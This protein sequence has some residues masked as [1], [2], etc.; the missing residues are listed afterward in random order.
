MREDSRNYGAPGGNDLHWHDGS[1]CHGA[2]TLEAC[3][4]HAISS[5][6]A[7][8][9]LERGDAYRDGTEVKCYSL[10]A[11]GFDHYAKQGRFVAEVKLVAIPIT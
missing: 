9:I 10:I 7:G 5:G 4:E 8:K 2:S 3:Q 6:W 1:T 11:S